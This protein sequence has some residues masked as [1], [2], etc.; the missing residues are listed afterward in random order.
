MTLEEALKVKKIC[1]KITDID[2]KIKQLNEC[3]TI[4]ITIHGDVYDHNVKV[5]KTSRIHKYIIQ[6]YKE[7]RNALIRELNDM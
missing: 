5:Y 2:F 3:S 1:D 4:D 6:A 7:E